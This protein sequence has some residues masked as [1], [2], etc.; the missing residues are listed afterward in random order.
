[1]GLVIKPAL[2]DSVRTNIEKDTS[3]RREEENDGNDDDKGTAAVAEF[4]EET[5]G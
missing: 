2:E 1:M 5:Q 4:E 3:E